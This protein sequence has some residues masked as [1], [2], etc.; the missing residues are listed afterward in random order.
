[1]NCAYIIENKVRT[2][3]QLGD[4]DGYLL[5]SFLVKNNIK[6]MSKYPNITLRFGRV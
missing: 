6:I 5:H 4:I 3:L 2:M 1:M